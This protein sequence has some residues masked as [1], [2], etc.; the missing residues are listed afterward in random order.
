MKL[1]L[2]DTIDAG[3]IG[4]AC[5]TAVVGFL[6]YF[7]FLLDPCFWLSSVREMGGAGTAV[8]C[9]LYFVLCRLLAPFPLVS[10]KPNWLMLSPRGG[11][12]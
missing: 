12:P 8:L 6:N 11:C 2:R 5:C 1:G 7:F 3:E 4:W 10:P 9:Y